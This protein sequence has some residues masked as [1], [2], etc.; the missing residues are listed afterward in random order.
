VVLA[1]VCNA[2]EVGEA[3]SAKDG[4]DDPVEIRALINGCPT[5]V[6]HPVARSYPANAAN[7]LLPVVMSC[8]AAE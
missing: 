5:G 3:E 8:S 6:P 2:A 7:P 4:V 1:P